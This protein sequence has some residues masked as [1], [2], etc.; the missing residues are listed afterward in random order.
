MVGD[1]RETWEAR[2]GSD[3]A[4]LTERS[5]V[6]VDEI[7]AKQRLIQLPWSQKDLHEASADSSGTER[8]SADHRMGI[9]T[10]R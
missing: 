5:V 9:E 6:V 7:E 8:L 2:S 1:G 10:H 3:L 4:K